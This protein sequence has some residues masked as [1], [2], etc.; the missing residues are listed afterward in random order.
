M[1]V[2]ISKEKLKLLLEE[3]IKC[4]ESVAGG[5]NL[6]AFSFDPKNTDP[7]LL[8]DLGY[9]E[10]REAWLAGARIKDIIAYLQELEELPQYKGK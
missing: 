10:N 4:W 2:V 7:Q 8:K 6:N 5:P 3:E 1:L 9:W